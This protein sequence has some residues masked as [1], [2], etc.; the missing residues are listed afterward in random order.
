MPDRSFL[1]WLRDRLEHIYDEHPDTD[2][3]NKLKCI[4]YAIPEDQNTPNILLEIE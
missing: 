1:L 2:F 3:M 4:A